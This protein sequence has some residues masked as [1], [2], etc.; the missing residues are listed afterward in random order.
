MDVQDTRKSGATDDIHG[1]LSGVEA[2]AASDAH[3]GKTAS[4]DGEGNE[5]VESIL[6][7]GAHILPCDSFSAPKGRSEPPMLTDDH[8]LKRKIPSDIRLKKVFPE[9]VGKQ[10]TFRDLE[11]ETQVL[12]L[13]R[14][15]VWENE[16]F[17]MKS[18]DTTRY[19]FYKD[20]RRE[21]VLESRGR[22]TRKCTLDEGGFFKKRVWTLAIYIPGSR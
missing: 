16:E 20:L 1:S 4:S 12:F 9:D 18:G 10:T 22:D 11:M 13:Y 8:F 21:L 7:D 3:T 17:S 6:S 14:Y 5:D 15:W 19:G 2:L